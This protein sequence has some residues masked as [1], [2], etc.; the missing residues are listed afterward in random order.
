MKKILS[1]LMVVLNIFLVSC[2]EN[3]PLN[4]TAEVKEEKVES[5]NAK[6]ITLS[7]MSDE[8]S[9]KEVKAILKT[10]LEEKNVDKFLK[11]VEDY[12]EVIEK[13]GL[14]ARF[15]EKE[16]P[17]YDV[18]KIA[19]LWSAK[20]GE[21]IGT[22]CRLNSFILLKNNI[23][24]KKG[25]IDDSLLFL[26]NS[27]IKTGN[28]FDEKETEQF[29]ILFSKIKTENTKDINVHAK[30][31]EEHFSNIKFDEN[32]RMISVVLHDNL[33]GDGLFVGHVGVL[34]KNK[35]EYLFIEKLSFEE[36]FQAIKF[37]SK[38]ECYN[39]LFLKYKH[40]HDETT[41]KPFIMDNEKFVKLDLYN[42][43]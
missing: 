30:K 31:M 28:L 32:A 36:P 18:E 38:E 13:N 37:K 40:Y 21:F 25:N 17:E 14:S 22:N 1:V 27:A 43:E 39:Y 23:E 9:I 7:N 10:Y 29:K 24:I 5:Q 2:Q 16:Q 35:D 8:D 41:A 11:G 26:D 3:K 20:K 6:K 12:N 33:D 19:K 34:V 15:E 4:N 42:K